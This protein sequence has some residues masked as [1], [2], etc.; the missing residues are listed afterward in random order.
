[1]KKVD[2]E[3]S[4][5]AEDDLFE[6]I[7]ANE[8]F[9]EFIGKCVTHFIHFVIPRRD[10]TCGVEQDYE[11]PESIDILDPSVL[12]RREKGNKIIVSFARW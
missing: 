9:R 10:Q 8:D 11:V 1:M 7:E 4:I 6:A 12:L 2:Y 5:C 3:I